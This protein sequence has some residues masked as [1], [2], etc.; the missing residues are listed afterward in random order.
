M[1]MVRIKPKKCNLMTS[2]GNKLNVS[3]FKS[4]ARKKHQS[5]MFVLFICIYK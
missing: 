4:N 1:I 3:L 2:T 5:G